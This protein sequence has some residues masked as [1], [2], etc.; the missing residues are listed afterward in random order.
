MMVAIHLP[1]Y[2]PWLGFFDKMDRADAFVLLDNVQYKKNE[3]QNR[4][5]IK[6]PQGVQW[7]TVPV[8]YSFP[9]SIV[10]VR[11]NRQVTWRR[12]QWQALSTNYARASVWNRLRGRLESFLDEEWGM[13]H[14]VNKASIELLRGEIGIDT[15]LHT[16]SE[17]E[18]SDEPTERLLDICRALE[19]DVYLA[20]V[21]GR[22]Y[23]EIDRFSAAGIEVV[24][25]DYEHPT[26]DQ[27]HGPFHSH[28]SA[29]DLVLNCGAASLEILRRGRGT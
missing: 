18:L 1:Q 3:W 8:T 14:Q 5:R 12:K 24:F 25:Q 19:A 2:M 17:M 16:A 26:Y 15:P 6:T 4:N 10:D 22:R 21:D 9:A 23:M 11:V 7:I 13:L 28:L 20:G 27:L 29:L